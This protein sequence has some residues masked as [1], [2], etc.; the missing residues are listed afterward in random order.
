[1]A[2]TWS[3]QRARDR[4]EA[5]LSEVRCVEV[6]EYS[7]E[8]SL[9]NIPVGRAYRLNAVHLYIDIVN[10][11][12][13]LDATEKEGVDVHRRTL[14]FLN[15]HY[16]AVDRIL[17]AT[18][19]TRVDYHNQRLHA[20]VAKPYGAS[21]EASRI[22]RAIAIAAVVSTMLKETGDADLKIPGAAV[23]VGIDSGLALAVNN[24]RKGDREPLFLGRPANAAAKASGASSQEGIFLTRGAASVIGV[25]REVADAG[26]FI[27]LTQPEVDAAVVRAALGVDVQ[28]LIDSW[29]HELTE[30]PVGD[31]VFSGHTPPLR[32]LDFESLTLAN[33]RRME[34]LAVYAD[35]DGFTAYVDSHIHSDPGSVVRVLHVLRAE[36]DSVLAVEFGGKRIRFIGDCVHG[37][38]VEGTAA[39]TDGE[40]TVSTGVL[41]AAALR[42]SF[43]V[44]L[45]MLRDQ[46]A[47]VDGLGL[48]IGLAFGPQALSRLGL[49]G[50]R[51][52]VCIGRAVMN[53]ELEQARSNGVQTAMSASANAVASEAVRF[54]FGAARQVANL[55]YDAAVAAMESRGDRAALA[56]VAEASRSVAPSVIAHS[57][58]RRRPHCG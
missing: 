50:D 36:L 45:E 44:A 1:M 30:H 33:S 32:D 56:A 13:M 39:E 49:K 18:E 23:R 47:P 20:V 16:R 38:L 21:S 3:K 8:M 31:I 9:E 51:V 48:A 24:G 17:R 5:R 12:E 42:S 19:T 41:C 26:D 28:K 29:R 22:D 43:N 40:A 2:W 4:I 27:R 58:N 35:L 46:G 57:A 54:I 52:R 7:R 6:L 11:G 53:A 34:A 10:L 25:A 14:R 55:T 15:L 37:A